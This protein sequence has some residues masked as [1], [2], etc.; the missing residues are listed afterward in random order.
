MARSWP[1][2]TRAVLVGLKAAAELNGEAVVVIS[3]PKP[4]NERLG[5]EVAS[6]GKQLAVKP[7]NLGKHV[8]DIT[9]EAAT[10][11]SKKLHQVELS[12][13]ARKRVLR[14]L[15]R[16]KAE[17]SSELGIEVEDCECLTDW[18]VKVVGAPDTVF[19]G[20]IYRLRVRFHADYPTA[21]PECVF[22]R[23]APVH[24]HIYSD[25]TLERTRSSSRL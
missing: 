10:A 8:D 24:E 6:T 17:D 13:A 18:V 4:P 22:M 3:H 5:V 9:A 23:P 1:I 20:E 12:P 2:G 16:M 21:P 14:D 19:A 11:L 7:A 15:R 25:G